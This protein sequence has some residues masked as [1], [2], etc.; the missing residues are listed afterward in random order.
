MRDASPTD[1]T[2]P[3]AAKCAVFGEWNSPLL[4]I[5]SPREDESPALS[6]DGTLLV[7]ASG[8]D[9]GDMELYAGRYDGSTVSDAM[10][11]A[12]LNTTA[13]DETSPAWS[14]DATKLYFARGTSVL[15]SEVTGANPPFEP[16]SV[17]STLTALQLGP[18]SHPRFT[19]DGLEVYFVR[20]GAGNNP[21]IFRAVRANKGVPWPAAGL[22]T[23]LSVP[24]RSTFGVAISPDGQTIYFT[25]DRVTGGSN[26]VFTAMRAAP[27]GA[28]GV[29]TMIP[30]I[31]QSQRELDVSH[32]G[33]TMLFWKPGGTG[34]ADI[35][36]SRRDCQ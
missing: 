14:H 6:P 22:V 5:S 11:I 3:D 12:N 27:N 26:E 10:S 15:T 9:P 33:T 13:A 4:L 8:L 7:W 31:G 23:E 36:I 16:A 30:N 34:D 18:I 35:F 19:M 29:P 2:G 32:D 24:Q 20:D 25:S 1:A 21:E 28:F 17:D